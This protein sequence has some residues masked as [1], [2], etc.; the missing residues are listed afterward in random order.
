MKKEPIMLEDMVAAGM[1]GVLSGIAG[2]ILD[3]SY[4]KMVV[5]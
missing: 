2:G 1:C 4:E 3:Q 5:Y